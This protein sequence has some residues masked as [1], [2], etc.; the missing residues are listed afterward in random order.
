VSQSHEAVNTAAE[1][2]RTPCSRLGTE[3]DVVRFS[4]RE[5]AVS[6]GLKDVYSHAI[7]TEK[8][9]LFNAEIKYRVEALSE[10]I[11]LE[12]GF[13][14]G[15]VLAEL[16]LFRQSDHLEKLLYQVNNLTDSNESNELKDIAVEL[17]FSIRSKLSQE[18][19]I[20]LDNGVKVSAA[21]DILISKLCTE[22][23]VRPDEARRVK[24]LAKI[25]RD[26][27]DAMSGERVNL[28]EFYSRSRQ[29]VAGTCVGIGQGHIGIQ[30]NIYDWVI[31]DEA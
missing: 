19:G 15:V 9:E 20:N 4:N 3:L 8:R 10:A 17:D 28:D 22:Y 7:T 25:S 2:I 26:M 21:K 5:G 1:R 12:P 6:P 27:Q 31:I 29:L 23:G 16:N 24:A 14:S 11:G 18:Y 30:E 13:I